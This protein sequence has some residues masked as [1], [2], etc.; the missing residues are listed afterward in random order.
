MSANRQINNNF[1]QSLLFTFLNLPHSAA[2]DH[3]KLLRNFR[4]P[5]VVDLP[6][7]R[8]FPTENWSSHNNSVT[9]RSG[10][11]FQALPRVGLSFH[12][13]GHGINGGEAY[14]RINHDRSTTHIFLCWMREYTS[15]ISLGLQVYR[16]RWYSWIY[17]RNEVNGKSELTAGLGFGR[18]SER[19]SFPNPRALSSRF[20]SRS[21]SYGKG[22]TGHHQL[23]SGWCCCFY[24]VQYHINDGILSSEYTPDAMWQSSVRCEQPMEF[25]GVVQ[26]KRLCQL[27][28]AIYMAVSCPS[29]PSTSTLA[30]RHYW[31]VNLPVPM[32]SRGVGALPVKTSDE[33]IIRKVLAVGGF[34]IQN[35]NFNDDTV[36]I[37]VQ[38][39]NF[40]QLHKLWVV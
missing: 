33:R 17:R 1:Y 36:S 8:R 30:G 23:V 34:D 14:G 22:G 19:N 31:A 21:N 26:I 4:L 2:S 28:P 29:L 9:A 13:T 5:G 3:V 40:D 12:Y 38:N 20:W 18:L 24:G 25:W 32:R 11:S 35:L 16:H 10:V 39:T 27:F 15:R 7:A 37:V 6:A